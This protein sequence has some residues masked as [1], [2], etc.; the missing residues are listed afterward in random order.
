[1]AATAKTEF[2]RHWSS[3][4]TGQQADAATTANGDVSVCSAVLSYYLKLEG[5]IKLS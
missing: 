3:D 4:S 2:C 5:E 1:M